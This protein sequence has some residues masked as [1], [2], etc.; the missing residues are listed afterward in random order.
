[1]SFYEIVELTGDVSVEAFDPFGEDH[2]TDNPYT[3]SWTKTA[4]D[5]L[6][7]NSDCYTL[8]AAA[9][10]AAFIPHYISPDDWSSDDYELL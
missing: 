9:I 4:M 7:F 6:G 10:T 2:V 8:F 5:E 3:N 1:M